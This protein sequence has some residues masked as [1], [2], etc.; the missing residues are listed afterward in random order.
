M[1]NYVSVIFPG[2]IKSKVLHRVKPCLYNVSPT[3]ISRKLALQFMTGHIF[4]GC[5]KS[6]P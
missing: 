3:N 4:H 2:Q 1:I 6:S 5:F